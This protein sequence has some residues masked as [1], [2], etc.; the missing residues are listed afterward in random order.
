[1]RRWLTAARATARIARRDA[2]R[3][4]GR[5]ALVAAMVGLPVLVGVGAAVLVQSS[6]MTPEQ[7]ALAMIP[8]G[9]QAWV[10]QSYGSPIEQDPLAQAISAP[11]QEHEADGEIVVPGR[12][13]LEVAIARAI[14]AGDVVVP[15]GT[16]EVRVSSASATAHGSITTG[17]AADLAMLARSDVLRGAW[18]STRSH[19]ALGA[20]L[21][22]TLGVDVGDGIDAEDR[23]GAV[24]PLEVSAI[25]DTELGNRDIVGVLGAVHETDATFTWFI[26]G[27]APVGWDAV[28]K[29]N[30][31]GLPVASRAVI[32]DPPP[33][34]RSLL[35]PE[36]ASS[37]SS[38]AVIIAAAVAIGALEVVLLIGPAFAVGARRRARQLAVI[39]ASGGERRTLRHVVL[40][41]GAVIGLV[42]SVAAG[43]IGLVGAAAIRTIAVQNGSTGFP[44]MRVPWLVVFGFVALGVL[45]A[46][47]AAW[48]PALRAGKVDVVAALAGR[49][50]EARP[51]RRVPIVGTVLVALGGAGAV[52]GAARGS[53]VMLVLGV[54][55]FQVGVVAASGGL[56]TLVGRLAPHAGVAGRLAI[57]DAARQ[58]GRTAPAVAAVIAAIAGVVAAGVYVQSAADREARQY[59][60]NAAVG[61]V[62][63]GFDG[64]DEWGEPLP[65]PDADAVRDIERDATAAFAGTA[66]V[67]VVVVGDGGDLWLEAVTPADKLCPEFTGDSGEEWTGDP[68][69]FA[70]GGATAVFTTSGGNNDAGIHV[71]VDDG[72]VVAALGIGDPNALRDG[73]ALVRDHSLW[74][75]GTAHL[76]LHDL[77]DASIGTTLVVP[78]EA[79]PQLGQFDIVL[80]PAV[81][82]RLGLQTAASGF[83]LEASG[84]PTQAE[85]ILGDQQLSGRAHVHVERGYEGSPPI[86]LWV[87]VIAAVV[88]G[89]GATGL[90]MALAAAEFRPD[91]ATLAAVGASPRVRRRVA[92][93]QS[94]VV[95][96]LGV[97]LG[98]LSGL[99]L[100]WVLVLAKSARSTNFGSPLEF[101]V[102]WLQVGAIA[103]GVPLLAIGGAYLLTRSHLP[104]GRRLAT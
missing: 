23:D 22:D 27:E 38:T 24:S 40:L 13:R 3:S 63:V 1:M 88:V 41:G 11:G 95:V 59:V 26:R 83:V 91:L 48:I 39:A 20:E 79:S 16:T 75:D 36:P 7:Q 18:P 52:A 12:A 47:A 4:R 68:R 51:R 69:C 46:V 6:I 42:A 92:A 29:L 31:V 21:A 104:M 34:P 67:P 66:T 99:M 25:L 28:R 32:A 76:A 17:P 71:L 73:R 102:P 62:L 77:T 81:V 65:P 37:S 61:T 82:D 9:A 90:A 33:T 87:L 2:V 80:P 15:V 53:S 43:A 50:S 44:G 78:A 70:A 96:V 101:V 58:R 45:L 55:V 86:Y 97:G 89:L 72:T 10:E 74:P 94:G 5:T 57:R 93:A 98:V 30:A 100:G 64:Y 103:V 54:L 8:P 19:V 35:D 56:V 85:A 49:R 60:P 14:P 84:T